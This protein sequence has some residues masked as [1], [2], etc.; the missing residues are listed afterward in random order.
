MLI[1][2]E[3][4]VITEFNEDMVEIVHL[5]SLD[6]DNRRFVPDEVFETVEQAREVVEWLIS[7]YQGSE[8]PFVYPILLKSGEN[9]GY[10]QAVPIENGFEI[11]YHVSRTYTGNGYATESLVAFLPII[12]KQLNI[13]VIYGFC[14]AEN[15]ASQ[16]VME[17]SGF[18]LEF[19]G[20]GI[21]HGHERLIHR[22]K[23]L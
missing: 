14:L 22:Y 9:I 17:K 3:R 23:Y 19:I 5:N 21:Y 4:L 11:G 16:R 12:M 10:V 20:Q 2:T 1:E 13:S 15:I 6:D 18:A 8:G 7:C